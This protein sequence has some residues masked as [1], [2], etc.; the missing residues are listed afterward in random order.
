MNKNRNYFVYQGDILNEDLD[1]IIPDWAVELY[2]SRVIH[3]EKDG[4]LY[5]ETL[6]NGKVKIN[7]GDTVKRVVKIEVLKNNETENI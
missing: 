4:E 5:I 2:K 1:F 3:Y 6:E 7:I